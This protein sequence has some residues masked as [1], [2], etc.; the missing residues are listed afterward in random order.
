M[1]PHDP[2]ALL[3][4]TATAEALTEMFLLLLCRRKNPDILNIVGHAFLENCGIEGITYPAKGPTTAMKTYIH[5]PNPA[6]HG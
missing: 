6:R 4:R 1:I 5:N 3:K 2:D